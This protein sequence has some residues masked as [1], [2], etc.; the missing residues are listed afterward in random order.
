VIAREI[1]VD[2]V[3][4]VTAR[5]R[6]DVALVGLGESSEHALGLIERIVQESACPVI[7]LIHARDPDFV[8][9]ASKRGVF[10]HIS[11]ADVDEWQSSIDITLRRFAE[12]H[13]L[14]G[15]FGRRAL[16]ERAKGI[17]MERH[18]I[19]EA[20]A[21]AMLRDRSRTDNRKLIDLAAAVVDGHRLLPKQP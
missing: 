20:S 8:R 2:D 19:D 21:F 17:L 7:A 12:F 9:E 13:D 3:G 14:A 4:A 6:P 11:D 1:D 15:A 16:T 10:A 5:E 18:A